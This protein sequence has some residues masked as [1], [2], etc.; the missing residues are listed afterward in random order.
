MTETK[1]ASAEECDLIDAA[2]V[3]NASVVNRLLKAGV[4]SNA[5]DHRDI[6]SDVT[7]LM[8]ASEG[9]HIETVR[10]LLKA[11]ADVS[12]R[13]RGMAG[14]E[15]GLGT[16]LQYA[17][18]YGHEEIAELLLCHGASASRKAAGET[19]L[20][21]AAY[22]GLLRTVTLLLHHDANPNARGDMRRMPLHNAA[23]EGH[24]HIAKVLLT[25]GARVNEQDE[26]GQTPFFLASSRSDPQLVD[27]LWRAGAD[28]NIPDK[29][30]WTP[31]MSAV[32][33]QSLETVR[34]VMG[35]GAAFNVLSSDGKT[36]LDYAIRDKLRQI[37]MELEEAGGKT[38]EK[39][40][41]RIE[42]SRK[43]EPQT[44]RERLLPIEAPALAAATDELTGLTGA[45]PIRSAE[46]PG[47]VFF[48]IAEE[49]RRRLVHEFHDAFL[50][51]GL[52]LF[53]SNHHLGVYPTT[54]KYEVLLAMGT[55]GANYDVSTEKVI[56]ELKGIEEEQPFVLLG[57]GPDFVSGEFTAPV[58]NSRALAKRLYELCPD[59]VDQG[60]GTLARA[61]AELK[62]TRQLFLWW[63]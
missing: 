14:I 25:A 42:P 20:A 1:P 58:K 48:K 62:R 50:K 3:G 29:S 54:D 15:S 38:A 32:V 6:P 10:L 22:R 5:R 27:L 35:A 47:G 60:A 28:P 16:A 53:A 37:A 17:I 40:G 46:I 8:R 7:P 45:D 59:I 19:P 2:R 39:L 41:Q 63:D 13:D 12:L 52:Y 36:A 18:N 26:L 56:S 33:S 51:R 24:I 31:L 55:N 23:S 30:K 44:I 21:Q 43:Q 57:V 34:A 61:A 49:E 4:N 9:G 11:G